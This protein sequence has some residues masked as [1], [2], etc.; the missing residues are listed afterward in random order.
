MDSLGHAKSAFTRHDRVEGLKGVL[1]R[2]ADVEVGSLERT[3]AERIPTWLRKGKVLVD[4][5]LRV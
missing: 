3:D 4:H 2:C 5:W 1:P